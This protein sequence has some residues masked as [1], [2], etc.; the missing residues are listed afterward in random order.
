MQQLYVIFCVIFCITF[1]ILASLLLMRVHNKLLTL[2]T[3]P[4][5]LHSSALMPKNKALIY[6]VLM[7]GTL[8]L[9]F[10]WAGLSLP[11]PQQ[12]WIVPLAIMVTWI[13]SFFLIITL[14]ALLAA[15]KHNQ[16][17]SYDLLFQ[18]DFWLAAYL[19]IFTELSFL[20]WVKEVSTYFHKP[21]LGFVISYSIIIWIVGILTSWFSQTNKS[22]VKWS[23]LWSDLLF[24]AIIDSLIVVMLSAILLCLTLTI[25]LLIPK[26]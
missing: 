6:L 22:A 3:L 11:S 9:M 19:I 8:S 7:V 4:E 25:I 21:F 17:L 15:M 18:Q 5:I 1:I 23:D 16:H 26:G 14:H 2:I 10:G 12:W 20:N 24:I 13:A